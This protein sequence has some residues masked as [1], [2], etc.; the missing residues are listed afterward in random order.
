MSV[1]SAKTTL[2]RDRTGRLGQ[3]LLFDEALQVENNDLVPKR[4]AERDL[5]KG[6]DETDTGNRCK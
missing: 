1:S 4:G 5:H 6:E 3:P 2:G